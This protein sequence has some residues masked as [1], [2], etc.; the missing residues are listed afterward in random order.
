[1]PRIICPFV[2]D[3]ATSFLFW[4][5]VH[6]ILSCKEVSPSSAMGLSKEGISKRR[7]KVLEKAG[8]RRIRIHELCHTYATL[9][10]SKGDSITDVSN[11]LDHYSAKLTLDVYNHWFPG[12]NKDQV[13]G[14]DN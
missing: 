11:R 4:A 2:N 7:R 12:D 8:L 9:R 1:M 14:L 10:I 3:L 13:D 5:Q 6:V